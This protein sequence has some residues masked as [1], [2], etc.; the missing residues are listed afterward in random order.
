MQQG[1]Q[2]RANYGI[3]QIKGLKCKTI[4]FLFAAHFLYYL[5]PYQHLGIEIMIF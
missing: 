3:Y 2:G 5:V 4:I 1:V